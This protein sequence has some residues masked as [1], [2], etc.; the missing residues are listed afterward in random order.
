MDGPTG[1]HDP[2]VP[3]HWN[4]SEVNIKIHLTYQNGYLPLDRKSFTIKF[5]RFTMFSMRSNSGAKVIIK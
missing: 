1:F 3:T 2:N 5:L 4:G